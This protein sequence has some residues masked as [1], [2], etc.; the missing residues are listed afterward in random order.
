MA[1]L[2]TPNWSPQSEEDRET[3]HQQLGKL[4]THH[5]FKSSRRCPAFLQYIVEHQLKGE[6]QQLKERIIGAEVFGRNADYDTSADPVVRTT[7]SEVRKRIAQYYQ[8]PG[9]QDEIRIELPLGSYSVE[10]HLPQPPAANPT[11]SVAVPSQEQP[12]P[13]TDVRPGVQKRL[14][15]GVRTAVIA[16][17]LAA[18]VA[19]FVWWLL[20]RQSSMTEQFWHPVLA[21]RSPVLVCLNTWDLSALVH[22]SPSPLASLLSQAGLDSSQWLPI[23]DAVA[24][25]QITGFL[26]TLRSEYRMQGARSTSLSDLMQSPSI[27]IGIFGNPWTQRVTESLRFRF[28]RDSTGAAYISDRND[29][30]KRFAMEQG[31]AAEGERDFAIVGRVYNPATGQ[32]CFI[33]AG[34][35]AAGTTAAAQF[36]TTSRYLDSLRASI[37]KISDSKNVEAVLSVQVIDGRPGAPHIEAAEAW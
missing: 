12:N 6:T 21:S 37:P 29:P 30:A 2:T 25:S 23:N 7:A 31:T 4:L 14:R 36:V 3:V 8:E 5:T 35:D 27:L 11:S 1:L 15:P 18:A 19:P 16:A 13:S 22:S 24:S 26:N 17:V 10:F 28:A 32:V 33:V 20:Q 34:L 9:H